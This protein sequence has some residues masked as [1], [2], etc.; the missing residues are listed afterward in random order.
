MARTPEERIF[1]RGIVRLGGDWFIQQGRRIKTAA[2]KDVL[3]RRLENRLTSGRDGW[4]HRPQKGVGLS[5]FQGKP[6][7]QQDRREIENRLESFT[8]DPAV[9]RVKDK[10]IAV[11]DDATGRRYVSIS[12]TIITT[13]GELRLTDRDAFEIGL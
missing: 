3:L 13:E 2:N 11:K 12:A 4:Y 5:E 10:E 8:E 7:T 9:L 6:L 1:G